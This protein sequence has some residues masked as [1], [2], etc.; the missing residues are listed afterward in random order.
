MFNV[1]P[2]AAQELLAAAARSDAAGMALRIAARQTADGSIEYGMGFDDERD[3]DE[4]A[5]FEGL[6]VLLGSPSR[7]LLQDTV[8]DFVELEPGQFGFVFIPPG[9]VQGGGGGCSSGAAK[10]K[11]GCGSGGCG[12][13]SC[14]A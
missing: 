12:G 2:T 14:G 4:P 11:S 1:T 9:E 6:T 13:G 8:L 7:P 10:A 3:D 5:V